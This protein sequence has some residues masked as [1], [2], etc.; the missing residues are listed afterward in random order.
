MSSF[1][2][3]VDLTKTFRQ[4]LQYSLLLTGI[5]TLLGVIALFFIPP[6]IPL[7]YSLPLTSQQLAG[8][9]W[10]LLFP[11]LS[12]GI[13]LLHIVLVGIFTAVDEEVLRLFCWLTVV[14]Q[15]LLVAVLVRVLVLVL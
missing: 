5:I 3:L 6:E 7:F 4:P 9:Y 13:T 10:I 15:L 1:N 11:G 14:L 2:S 12:L 8:Q